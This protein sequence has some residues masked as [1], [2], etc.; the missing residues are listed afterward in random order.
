MK[1]TRF[2]H[3]TDE[4]GQIP[5][6]NWWTWPHFITKLMKITRFQHKATENDQISS[7]NWW[8]WQ[9]FIT[10][11]MIMTRFHHNGWTWSDCFMAQLM[12]LFDCY[13]KKTP[14]HKLAG[15]SSNHIRGNVWNHNI[16]SSGRLPTMR[17]PTIKPST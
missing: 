17:L 15:P 10:K 14:V 11:L 3:K 16:R 7:H 4:N 2:H 1:I 13:H 9:D 5:S 12:K 8:K 6:Q